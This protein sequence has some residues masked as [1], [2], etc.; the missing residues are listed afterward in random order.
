ML[1]SIVQRKDMADEILTVDKLVTDHAAKTNVPA[2]KAPVVDKPAD[3]KPDDKPAGDV[4]TVDPVKELLKEFDVES[5]DA[6]RER[7]KP[8]P[9]VVES[10]EEKE[11]RENL[12]KVEMQKYAVEN[13]LMK[14]DEFARLEALKAKD[15]QALVYENWLANWKEENPDVDAADIEA[16]SREDFNAEYHLDSDNEKKKARG[17]AKIEKEAKE[18]RNPLESSFTKVKTEF[19]EDRAIT[20]NLPDYNKKLAGFIQENIPAKIKLFETKDGEEMV[21]VEIEL[22]DEQRREIYAKVDKKLRN[23]STYQLYTKNDLKQLAEVAKKEAEAEIWNE[24]REAGL[25]KI[26]ET[27]LKRGDEKGYKRGSVGAKNPFPLVKDGQKVGGTDHQSAAQQVLDS[28]Q[29]KK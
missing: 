28:L 12:Y 19:D 15:N 23:A 16:R 3:T 25:K 10:P 27:F 6:L 22:T 8:K 14:P 29:G 13:G 26:A 11:K 24:H 2:D 1:Y 17:V 21:P 7:L 4:L 18:I 20:K 9:D 5:V